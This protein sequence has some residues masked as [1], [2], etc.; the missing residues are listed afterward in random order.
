MFGALKCCQLRKN[1]TKHGVRGELPG[2]GLGARSLSDETPQEVLRAD[3]H[4]QGT[5]VVSPF[6]SIGRGSFGGTARR[7]SIS[8]HPNPILAAA[9]RATADI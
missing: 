6:V 7:L 2:Y 4:T 5:R 9:S 3:T 8:R 1:Q